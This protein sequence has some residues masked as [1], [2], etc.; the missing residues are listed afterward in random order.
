MNGKILLYLKNGALEE[1]TVGFLEIGLIIIQFR[2]QN[3]FLWNRRN[4][5][6]HDGAQTACSDMNHFLWMG[7]IVTLIHCVTYKDVFHFLNSED[8]WIFRVNC[9]E[10]LTD[11][12]VKPLRVQQL[13]CLIIRRFND[14]ENNA[15]RSLHLPLP[16]MIELIIFIT[17]LTLNIMTKVYVLVFQ[18]F[19]VRTETLV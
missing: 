1:S 2:P 5:F 8:F 15:N 11:V 12:L 19:T 9:N 17:S 16:Y 7:F 13:T 14:Q 4:D 3:I 10:Y 6:K 18:F